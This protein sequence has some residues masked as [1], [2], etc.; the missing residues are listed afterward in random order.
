M[1]EIFIASDSFKITAVGKTSADQAGINWSINHGIVHLG[2]KGISL[3]K[4]LYYINQWLID[5]QSLISS[6]TVLFKKTFC[7]LKLNFFD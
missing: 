5:K 7:E 3:Y 6:A 1:N 4:K 2:A